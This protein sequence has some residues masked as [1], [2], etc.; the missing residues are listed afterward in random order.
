M[1]LLLDTDIAIRLPDRDR[2]IGEALAARSERKLISLVTV[3][4]LEGGVAAKAELAMDRRVA[5]DALLAV[6]QVLPLDSDVVKD[7]S[8]ILAQAGFSRRRILDRLIA[9]TAVVH[10][11]TLITINGAD[12]RDIPDLKLEVW[13]T[14]AQ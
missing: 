2:S 11:L 12:F 8:D 14:A 1:A 7:Y 13:P 6:L 3:I 10:D 9:A 5:L 4:E